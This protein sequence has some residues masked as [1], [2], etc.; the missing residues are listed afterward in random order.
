MIQDASDQA[1]DSSLY[2]DCME[3]AGTPVMD[4]DGIP[5]PNSR[6]VEPETKAIPSSASDPRVQSEEWQALLAEERV[7]TDADWACRKDVYT[8]HIGDLLPAIN[9]FEAEHE[10]EIEQAQ[11]EWEVIEDQAEEL[12]YTGQVGPLGR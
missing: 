12:G 6:R 11:Q 9:R 8:E 4:D 7:I 1:A 10:Q 2:F 5:W 3:R